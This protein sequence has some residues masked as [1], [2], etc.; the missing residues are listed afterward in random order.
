[1][2]IAQLQVADEREAKLE[3]GREPLEFERIA[4]GAQ[5]ADDVLEVGRAEVRQ[6]P[7]VMD[8]RAPADQAVFVGLV[9]EPG[10]EAA[11]EEMLR[12]AHARVRRHLEGAHFDEP[13]AARAGFGRVEFINGKLGAVG[14]A[15]GV[16]EQVAEQPVAQPRRRV[17][18]AAGVAFELLER[19]FQ[20]VQRIVP[21]L[22]HARRLRGRTGC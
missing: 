22:V 1:M 13:E 17:P 11:Q 6:Q 3:V 9:P 5:V 18:Q 2:K 16:N 15:A 14:V 8:V 20:F 10:D 12:E 21:R 7:A 4:R 19:D